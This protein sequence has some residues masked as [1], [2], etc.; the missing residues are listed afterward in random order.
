MIKPLKALGAL[1]ALVA[2]LAGI[3]AG[4]LVFY[5]NP[6][7]TALPTG[8]D[9][10]TLLTSRDTLGA[11]LFVL[12]WIGWIA[13][14]TFALSVGIELVA[15]ARQIQAPQ[16]RGLGAQQG[17]AALLIAAIAGGVGAPA[18]M[19]APAPAEHA[20]AVQTEILTM[21]TE[22]PATEDH[23]APEATDEDA[24]SEDLVVTVQPG[25]S[26]W[27]LAEKH[28]GDGLQYKTI[29]AANDGRVQSDGSTIHIGSD[30]WLEEGWELVILGAGT[31]ETAPA[32]QQ[33]QTVTVREGDT[34]SSIAR[35]HLGDP[36]RWPEIADASAG[37]TQPG[38]YT[39]QDPDQID[40]G[41]TLIIPA[42]T[43]QEAAAGP[44]EAEEDPTEPVDTSAL[45]EA[46]TAVTDAAE[47]ASAAA[48][49]NTSP[50]QA[51]ETG[52]AEESPVESAPAAQAEAP[53]SD[54]APSA[55][56]EDAITVPWTGVGSILAASILSTVLARRLYT[57]R[58]RRADQKIP[59]AA[60]VDLDQVRL[61]RIEDPTALGFVDRALRTLSALQLRNGQTL[62]DVRLARLT[63]SHLEIYAAAGHALPAPFEATEDPATWLL[64]RTAPLADDE[65]IGDIVAPYPALVTIGTDHEG[66]QILVDL[67]HLAA[68]GIHA[69][70]RTS[71]P[72]MRA[73]TVS[74]ATSQ[75][76]DDLSI[77]TVG[78]CP[79]LEDALGSGRISY[80][81]T[82]TDLLDTLE[83]KLAHDQAT[84]AELGHDS[85]QHARQAQDA[86][87]LWAPEI[88]IIGTDLSLTE[89][90]RLQRI[91]DAQPQIAVAVISSD[92]HTD[93]SEWRM[94]IESLEAA[95][96]EP[97]GLELTPQHLTDDDYE[98]VLRALNTASCVE[99]ITPVDQPTDDVA[100]PAPTDSQE[101]QLRAVPSVRPAASILT[102]EQRTA[103]PV[104]PT[105]HPYVRVL[106]P[107]EVLG[108]TGPLE[109]KRL[110]QLTEA[111]CYIH[112][113]PGR[114][115]HD[116]IADL[117][118]TRRP[119]DSARHQL[120]SRLRK[121][122]G[123]T[124]EG[125]P[126]IP[127]AAGDAG[128]YVLEHIASDW[129]TVETI[130]ADPT[131]T[132]TEDLAEALKLVRGCPFEA[133][134]RRYRW[135][136][137]LQYT[138]LNAVLDIAHELARRALDAGDTD[139][140]LWATQQGLLVESLHEQL[141]RDRLQAA[142]HDPDLHQK[143]THELEAAIAALDDD[144]DLLPQTEALMYSPTTHRIAI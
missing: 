10:A 9:I 76:A 73:L 91:V 18:A 46:V 28:L 71:M 70:A 60:T 93:L 54:A 15:R 97:L 105:D 72:V 62:P 69:S 55:E 23:A 113:N 52:A 85:A 34:L 120:I 114:S 87:D 84:L 11:L 27:G 79:E 66:H 126:Y 100:E 74:L 131:G 94:H 81:D 107:V 142:S 134:G 67:E 129:A 33:E 19:A 111:T 57:Q 63:D 108:A 136:I 35:E 26:A 119:A 25:D 36:E 17:A 51:E 124:P 75:W 5:G 20:P 24:A 101:P 7:P 56:V 135:T 144:Y 98:R 32:A 1:L 143:T 6:I 99:P 123:T 47:G 125:D 141:W 14:G 39:L 121:W 21:P 139:T 37:I 38:G 83:A 22:T 116:F 88:I 130:A 112:L 13:W 89:K 65:T 109:E 44:Q 61:T 106:G 82:V 127:R 102:A 103:E 8:N 95:R 78:V 77:T 122:L 2:L 118:P 41:W 30:L 53:A 117:W 49:A 80:R 96:L 45:D 12:V 68:L 86:T 4:L 132:S 137:T 40:I 133:S 48:D 29:I 31:S 58:K 16:I 110:A 59:A 42:T 92:Q 115:S 128:G 64:P 50:E 138:M 43:A 90:S 104:L 140:A 3:P